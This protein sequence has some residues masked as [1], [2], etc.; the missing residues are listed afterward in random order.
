M[1]G[2]PRAHRVREWTRDLAMGAGFAFAGRQ[3]RLRTLLT[4]VGV[5]LGVAMLLLAAAVPSIMS[6]QESRRDAR[7]VNGSVL[8]NATST[9]E[10]RATERTLLTAVANTTFHGQDIDGRL[11]Q[12]DGSHP[13]TPPGTERIPGPGE[14]VVSPALKELLDSAEGAELAKRLNARVV[15]VIADDGLLGPADLSFY[16]G[17]DTLR[18]EDAQRVKYFGHVE[19][20]RDVDPLLILLGAVA[21]A[22]LLMPVATFIATATR[23]GGERRDQRLAALRLVGADAAMTRRIAAGESLAGA[24]LGLLLGGAVFLLGRGLAADVTLFDVSVFPA[25]VVPDPVLGA[26]VVLG[27]PLVTVGAA[28][29]ALRGVTIEPVRVTRESTPRPRR[30]WWRLLPPVVGLALLLP[31]AGTLGPGG[32]GQV[33]EFQVAAGVVALLSGVA[34]L[35]PWMVERL[36][37]KLRGGPVSWQLAVRRLQL[38]SGTATR[39]VSGITIAVAGAVAL[40][41]LFAGAQAEASHETGLKKS[42]LRQVNVI[43]LTVDTAGA[44]KL[45]RALAATP[46]VAGTTGF[47]E[48]T[49]EIA[50]KPAGTDAAEY[51]Q[52]IVGDCGTLREVAE[53]GSCRDGQVFRAAADPRDADEETSRPAPP[54]PGAALRVA[55]PDG[56][57]TGNW[58]IPDDTPTVPA[59]PSG[60]GAPVTGI[61]VT[62]GAL[63]PDRLDLQY[64][65][66]VRLQDEEPEAL[67]HVRTTVFRQSPAADVWLSQPTEVS[68]GF[69]ELSRVVFAAATAVLVLIAASMVVSQAEQL[70]ERRRQLA[71]LVAFG[72]RRGTL[73]ASVLWQTAI[74][75]A[76]GL[77]LASAFGLGLGWTLLKV[78]SRPVADWGVV[79]PMFAVGG[80]LVAVVTL[81]SLPLLWRMMR[82][83][84]LRTE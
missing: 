25:D 66:S 46:G 31:L 21:C 80:G 28:V 12:A 23:F 34:L 63:S 57:G 18:A 26:L 45:D 72:T 64:T 13:V 81:L 61:L 65:G 20:H 43:D 62:P 1:S 19:E 7:A 84:G 47:L 8:G 27:L 50:G 6:A 4:A 71:V 37:G 3:G 52:V 9:D 58:R 39:A 17:S 59:K 22:V 51:A 49:Q 74:P 40:Q 15:G 82:P 53:I 29:F 42:A 30:L 56:R 68:A 5:G 36:V 73:G 77:V 76:L 11:L 10:S 79:W 48:S 75:V 67:E 78:I 38:S 24:V 54:R 14:I 44:R 60:W 70:R 69:A 83:A 55:G 32:G 2:R 35:L 16:L 33:N 41:L